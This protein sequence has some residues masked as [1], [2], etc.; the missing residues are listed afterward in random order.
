MIVCPTCQTEN[1]DDALVCAMC[2]GAIGR[3]V[4]AL[5]A[6]DEPIGELHSVELPGAT[7]ASR[8]LQFE[9]RAMRRSSRPPPGM[10]GGPA[11]ASSRPP[12]RGPASAPPR[13]P[14]HAPPP[15]AT[16]EA[17]GLE[18]TFDVLA[19]PF[20]FLLRL[21]VL[22]PGA[23]LTIADDTRQ[24][25]SAAPARLA[26]LLEAWGAVVCVLPAMLPT[27]GP[28]Y[29]P[30]VV[31]AV[32]VLI[33]MGARLWV[34]R[35]WNHGDDPN[36]IAMVLATFLTFVGVATTVAVGAAAAVGGVEAPPGEPIR[37]DATGRLFVSIPLVLYA[38]TGLAAVVRDRLRTARQRHGA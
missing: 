22:G 38:L 15:R 10:S 20:D 5:P 13:A 1:R 26:F 25:H 6:K 7:P 14:S 12:P 11:R 28:M 4:G 16:S 8:P 23:S 9:E 31:M 3:I 35:S 30:F 33:A 36:P 21:A 37:L 17:P 2:K 27:D 18:R 29:V 24:L 34:A 19:S 32:L